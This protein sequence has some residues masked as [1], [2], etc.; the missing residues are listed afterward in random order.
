MK[1][2]K[3]WTIRSVPTGVI[4][5]FRLLAIENDTTISVCLTAALNS[6]VSETR[7]HAGGD[8]Q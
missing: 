2:D 1:T 3:R 4:K 8:K 7:N 5:R 6:W